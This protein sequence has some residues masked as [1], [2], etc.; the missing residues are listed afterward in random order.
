MTDKIASHLGKCFV[1][2]SDHYLTF[3][4]KTPSTT[5]SHYTAMDVIHHQSYYDEDT[6]EEDIYSD[7]GSEYSDYSGDYS[8]CSEDYSEYSEYTLQSFEYDE[9]LSTILEETS[10]DLC[11]TSDGSMSMPSLDDLDTICSSAEADEE[12]HL[13]QQV[14]DAFLNDS[15]SNIEADLYVEEEDAQFEIDYNVE[16]DAQLQEVVK[17]LAAADNTRH[18]QSS[19]SRGTLSTASLSRASSSQSFEKTT[20]LSNMR[21]AGWDQPPKVPARSLSSLV[22]VNIQFFRSTDYGSISPMGELFEQSD[23]SCSLNVCLEESEKPKKKDENEDKKSKKD[24]KTKKEKS[25]KKKE[26]NSKDKKQS[27]TKTKTLG[28]A[29]ARQALREKIKSRMRSL[30]SKLGKVI[31]Y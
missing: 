31:G 8:E 9:V 30:D 15:L 27:K 13:P 1:L 6:V 7:E 12:N 21:N 17:R 19:S 22:G 18:S 28:T 2:I 10:V 26:D 11:T 24:N 3:S 5:T 20:S 16:E 4:K 14:C 25:S 23:E 29:D